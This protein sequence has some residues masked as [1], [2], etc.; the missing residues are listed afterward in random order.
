MAK[1]KM[2]SGSSAKASTPAAKPSSGP[3]PAV[4]PTYARQDVVFERGEGSW[5]VATNGDRYLDFTSGIAV[6]ALGHCHPALVEAL[7][8]QAGMLW[9]T[10]NLYR[11]KNQERLAERL[12]QNSFA[13]IV[14]FCNSGAEACEGAIKLARKY[15]AA[16]GSPDR[17]AASRPVS[18]GRSAGPR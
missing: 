6:N 14:F 1:P 12:V 13:D 5:L 18:R 2:S 7:R 9:H 11:V 8:E 16:G 3:H 15:H 17:S 4:M 10:S